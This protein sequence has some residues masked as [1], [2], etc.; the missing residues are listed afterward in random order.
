M[1]QPRVLDLNAL[2]TQVANMLPPVLGDDIKLSIDLDPDLGHVKADPALLEQVIMNLVFNARDAMQEGGELTIQT[3][4]VDLDDNFTRRTSR[5]TCGPLRRAS[6][7]RYRPWHERRDAI[8]HFRAIFY[9]E[10]SRQGNG[11]RS[12]HRL[13][14]RQPEWRLYRRFQQDRNRHG[15]QNIFAACRRARGSHG[16]ARDSCAGPQR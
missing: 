1:L 6:H 2:T 3:F 12:R 4:N 14:D 5:S 8:A 9:H 13:R 10:G 15:N 7:P 11:P 16:S